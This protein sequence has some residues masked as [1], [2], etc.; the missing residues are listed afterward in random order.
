MSNEEMHLQRG[1]VTKQR[2][3]VLNW[4]KTLCL[5]VQSDGLSCGTTTQKYLGT[6]LVVENTSLVET[7]CPV[8]HKLLVKDVLVSSVMGQ[9]ESVLAYCQIGVAYFQCQVCGKV[10]H[11][12]VTQF[13]VSIT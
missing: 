10:F 2:S 1:R 11:E 4:L 3:P 5:V 6:G 7:P 8:Y 12:F 9:H 13:G